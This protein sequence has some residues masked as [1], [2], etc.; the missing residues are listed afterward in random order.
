[1][2]KSITHIS[3]K[4]NISV[5]KNMLYADL[6]HSIQHCCPAEKLHKLIPYNRKG[7]GGRVWQIWQIFC[8]FPNLSA[9]WYWYIV[10]MSDNRQWFSRSCVL[11]AHS[12]SNCN[13]LPVQI[14][15]HYIVHIMNSRMPW[16]KWCFHWGICIKVTLSR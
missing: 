4:M 7:C 1:M 3:L 9:I 8:E 14:V 16:R 6:C 2:V 12:F 15:H 13:I 10:Q 11:H 5:T